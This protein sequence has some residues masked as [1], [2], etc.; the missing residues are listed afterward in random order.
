MFLRRALLVATASFFISAP[1]MADDHSDK[2]Y[3]GQKAYSDI[4]DNAGENIGVA[5]YTQGAEGV[6]IEITAEGL[7]AGKHGMHFHEV[8]TCADHD[9]FKMAK[10]HI[11]PTGKP[12]GFLNKDGGPHEGNLPNLIV[13]EDGSVHVELY[14]KM[15]SL[16]GRKGEWG[17]QPALLDDDGSVLMVHINEDDHKTQPIGGAG[18]RIACGV[19][20]AGDK[21]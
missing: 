15:V 17:D 8:G 9:H 10:G 19:V 7:P 2:D 12:H 13:H 20:K 11:M 1:A 4:I 3:I 5:Q 6:L 14:S 16:N 18:A 21:K